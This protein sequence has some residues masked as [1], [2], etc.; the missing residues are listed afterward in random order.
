MLLGVKATH[1]M[2]AEITY[3]HIVNDSFSVTVKVYRDCNGIQLG[4]L[5]LTLKSACKTISVPLVFKSFRDVTGIPAG[6]GVNSRCSGSFKYGIEEHIYTGGFKLPNDAC[7]DYTLSWEQQARN[8]AITTGAANYNYYVETKFN[9]CLAPHNSSPSFVSLPTFLI[10]VGTNQNISNAAY[11]SIDNDI[12]TYELT[13]PLEG[14]G[15]YIPYSGTFAPNKPLTFLGFPNINLSLPSGFHFDSLTSNMAFRPTINNQVTVMVV[16]VNEFRKINGIYTQIGS[17]LRDAQVIVMND[18]TNSA[19]SLGDPSR[20]LCRKIGNTCFTIPIT[21]GNTTDTVSV[22]VKSSIPSITYNNIGTKPSE[23][24]VEVCMYID[25]A[26]LLSTQ[27]PQFTVLVDDNHCPLS[28]KTSKTYTIDFA[29][30]LP[31]S[32]AI[33]TNIV[34][35]RYVEAKLKNNN[36]QI[37]QIKPTDVIWQM[38]NH[39]DTFT[40]SNNTSMRSRFN[41]T[42]WVKI[43]VKVISSQHCTT[44]DYVDSVYIGSERFFRIGL[45]ADKVFCF[46]QQDTLQVVDTLIKGVAPYTY[47]WSTGNADTLS[48]IIFTPVSGMRKYWVEV[49]DANNCLS[50][51]AVLVGSFSPAVSFLAPLQSCSGQ[52]YVAKANLSGSIQP[53]YEWVGYSTNNLLLVDTPTANKN[54]RFVLTD[55]FGCKVDTSIFV[56]VYKPQISISGKTTLCQYDTLTLQSNKTG[57]LLPTQ[58]TWQPSAIISDNLTVLPLHSAGNKII[59]ATIKDGFGCTYKDS[60]V[61]MINA[62][63]TINLNPAGPYCETNGNISLVSKA[64]PSG[65]KWFG[66][67]V[68]NDSTFSP[69]IALKGTNTIAY[70]YLD[71]TTGC[72]GADSLQVQVW[73]QPKADFVA[74]KTI[75]L[76]NDTIQFINITSNPSATANQWNM[77]DFGKAGNIQTSINAQHIYA[78][79]GAYTV[80]LWVNNGVCPPD[81]IIKTAYIKIGSNYLSVFGISKNKLLIYPNP[82]KDRL[83][84]EAD[85]AL[86]EIVLVDV[87]GRRYTVESNISTTKTEIDIQHLSA[88]IYVIEANDIEGNMYTSK[89]QISR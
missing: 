15:M 10:G 50:T 26:M 60:V 36:T 58:V 3:R 88:G 37:P 66:T 1:L 21:D 85:N 52:P 20:K 11:D 80:K 33:E 64:S 76:P 41:D 48:T 73:R 57:G 59:T 29:D 84:I 23:P 49:T 65:G 43:S 25:S 12:V 81:S 47:K 19:P 38:A 77:G 82:A 35:C 87:L 68:I 40:Y 4:N 6:C 17:V 42:G 69:V 18:S 56:T 8:V 31:D 67:G 75:G 83:T 28:I 22:S 2:S 5:P 7:C 32:F 72:Y 14:S 30:E 89:V 55:S 9:K 62:S 13:Q 34:D 63:P 61:V 27:K 54:Y 44:R 24:I 70:T 71:T 79:T 39:K 16:K 53:T 45:G 78:D 74:L 46:K 86:A 51:D